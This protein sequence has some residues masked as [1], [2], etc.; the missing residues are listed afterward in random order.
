MQ[1]QIPDFNNKAIADLVMELY[2]I[3]GEISSLVSYEDQ[4]ARIKT[5]NGSYVLK[6]ANK[7]LPIEALHMQTDAVEHVR[8]TM[9]ELNVP[10]IIPTKSGELITIINGFFIRLLTFL[11][12]G[13]L[14]HAHRSPS[15]YN[16]IGC[17]MGQFSV[18]MQDY[19]HP[20]A[21]RPD[22][23]WNLDNILACKRYLIDVDGREDR[24]RIE[25]S[26]ETYIKETL[27]ILPSLRRSVI[28]NDANEQNLLVA[29]ET[30]DKVAGLIDFGDLQLAT[31]V[32]EIAIT[33]AYALLGEDNIEM[34]AREILQGYMQ[35]FPLDAREL[36]VL[37]N[38]ISMRLIQSIIMSSNSA[39]IFPN[40]DYI[41]ISQKP[42]RALLK[43]LENEKS[44]LQWIYSKE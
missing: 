3:E 43:E 4:N 31:H 20:N 2:G 29:V 15:L 27:L 14:G 40:N 32:N 22:D 6:I 38:L 16:N 34:A 13:I 21:H 42:A 5:S 39:K 26:Y 44:N 17:F 24:V 19:S 23:L 36:E 41:L 30:P 9:P 10:Q 37:P 25:R 33:M 11:E 35:E 12:G 7:R 1:N 28:H 18:A 8:K